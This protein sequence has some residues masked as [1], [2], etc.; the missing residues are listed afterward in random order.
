MDVE[1]STEK[2]DI[3]SFISYLIDNP[4]KDPCTIQIG[5]TEFQSEEDTLKFLLGVF[6]EGVK[7]VFHTETINWDTVDKSDL[8]HMNKYFASFGWNIIVERQSDKVNI[9]GY[10]LETK[11][12]L[13]SSA[14]VNLLV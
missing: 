3:H 9:T 7:K 12:L 1:T 4:P 8:K 5:N 6:C 10:N 2:G 13:N 14:T 11:K